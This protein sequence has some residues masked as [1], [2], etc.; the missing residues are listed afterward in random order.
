MPRGDQVSRLYKLVMALAAC[1][2]G[3][4]AAELARRHRW[5]PRTVY[6]DLHA[7]EQA[8]F[9]IARS[10]GARW[11]LVDGWQERVP[12]PLPLGQLL[13]LHVARGLMAPLRGSPVGRDFDA[14][15]ERLTG[16]KPDGATSQGE[17][18]PRF[19]TVIAARSQLAID[20]AKHAAVL[21][22]LCHG[23]EKQT[24]VRAVY[25]AESRRELTRRRIDPYCLYYDPQLEALYVFAWCHLRKAMRTFAVHRFR[26]AVLTT[27]RFEVPT[28][29]TAEG[30]LRGA[31]RIWREENTVRVRLAVDREAAGW[32]AE[33]RWHASQKVRRRAGGSSEIEFTV[34]GVHEIKR[35][36][37]GLGAVVEVVEPGWLREEVGREHEMAWRRSSQR[38]ENSLSPADSRFGHHRAGIR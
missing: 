33:R 15:Y 24:A 21:E 32:V 5:R 28:G 8:G 2:Y 10:D 12:F 38:T 30:Y 7:L 14:L 37:L 16:V 6:R 19:R 9:P 1:R 34:D 13:G 22:T 29:F 11:K 36:I 17:L 31:F 35:F 4:P 23:C 27:E 18:F 20:Y 26:R 25:Y 3:L